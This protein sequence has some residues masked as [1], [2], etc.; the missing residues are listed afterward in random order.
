MGVAYLSDKTTSSQSSINIPMKSAYRSSKSLH[1]K[2]LCQ[3]QKKNLLR[4]ERPVTGF[5]KTHNAPMK[6]AY[7][8]PLN[9]LTIKLWKHLGRLKFRLLKRRRYFTSKDSLR[10][11][12][13]SQSSQP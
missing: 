9:I 7:Q 2:T 10:P 8:S 5:Y 13:N 1:I 11:A 3:L 12:Y 4:L 6:T